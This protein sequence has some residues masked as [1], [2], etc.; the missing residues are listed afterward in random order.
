M[1]HAASADPQDAYD[2]LPCLCV[3]DIGSSARRASTDV[4]GDTA[5][6][7]AGKPWGSGQI[8]SEVA[9]PYFGKVAG[10]SASDD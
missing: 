3:V 7:G 1:F 4:S 10:G 6:G 5:N 8:W 2:N 9:T